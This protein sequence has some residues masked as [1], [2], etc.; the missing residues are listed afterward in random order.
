M[1]DLDAHDLGPNSWTERSAVA[2]SSRGPAVVDV[3]IRLP[4]NA[5]ADDLESDP[6]FVR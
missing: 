3:E 4:N 1:S 6:G 2:S 5:G